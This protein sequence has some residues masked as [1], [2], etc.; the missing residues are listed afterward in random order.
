MIV[1]VSV[2][3]PRH[4]QTAQG[5][6]HHQRENCGFH[7]SHDCLLDPPSR[8]EQGGIVFP[9]KSSTPCF[10]GICTDGCVQLAAVLPSS[11]LKGVQRY[12]FL[13]RNSPQLFST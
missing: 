9:T 12:K 7:L 3:V 4:S 2:M 5:Q 10:P 1:I 11:S 6:T 8:Q 13:L